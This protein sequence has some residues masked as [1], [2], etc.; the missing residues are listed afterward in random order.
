MS[1][2]QLGVK[3]GSANGNNF[4]QPSKHSKPQPLH[5]RLRMVTWNCGGLHDTKYSEIM[6]WLCEEH[7]Q[8]R[9]VHIM[10]LQETAWILDMEYVTAALY[11]QG[12]QW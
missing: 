1:L 4:K 2:Q 5:P 7:D 6:R 10:V 12:P 11:P 8:G 9:P 3:I